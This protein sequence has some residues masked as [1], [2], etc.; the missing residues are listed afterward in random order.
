MSR[1][2]ELLAAMTPE[3]KI[4]QLVMRA[5]GFSVTGPV[6]GG[7]ATDDVR[8]GRTGSLLNVFG[9]EAT[10]AIQRVAVEESRLR[11][12]LLL[13]FDV[14]HGHRTVFPLPIAEAGAF[15]PDL[16]E[17]TARASAVEAAKDGVKLVFAPMIDIARDPRWG[18]I[19]ESPGEDPLI[20]ALFAEAKVAGL[21]GDD[22]GHETAVAATAKH[23]VAYGAAEAG[24][25]YA[26]TDLSERT[27]H[28]T[29]LPPFEAA[30]QSGVAAVMPAFSDLAGVPMTANRRLL[31]D[32]L[33]G[34]AG[35]EGVVVSDYHALAELIAHG[36]AADAVEAAAL[37][38]RAG[39]DIDM[40]SE[41]YREG[42]AP[43]LARGL[44][45]IEAV[46]AAVRR[47]LALKERLALFERPYGPDAAPEAEALEERRAARRLAREAAA[48]SI[49][50]LTNRNATLPLPQTPQRIAV[51]GPLADARADMLGC[52]SGAGE[53]RDA[54][55]VFEGLAAARPDCDWRLAPGI[56]IRDGDDSRVE[57]ALGVAAAADLVILCLGEASDMS[58][59][60]ASR[61]DLALPGL[62]Q[63]FADR[64]LALGRPVVA[65]LS[66]GRPL[67]VQGLAEGAEA[68]LATWFLGH[69][70]G[71]ALADVLTGR[72]GPS[73]RLPV[74]WPR[75]VGQ[76]PLHYDARPSGR[77]ASPEHYTSKYID[78]PVTPLFPFGHGLTYG[79]FEL[80]GLHADR[81]VA[82]SG[83]TVAVTA[84]LANTGDHF[85]EE[86][87]F[88][89]TRRPVSAVARPRLTLKA[90]G[91]LA[92]APGARGR[93]T[94]LLPVEALRSLD[95]DLRPTLEPGAVELLVGPS[96][97]PE[98]LVSFWIEVRAGR[99]A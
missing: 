55:S 2:D 13:G 95:A 19:A 15:D 96:A 17:R 25:D 77:P 16:W 39:V 53:A 84:E 64:V 12:P 63:D 76:V 30:V 70:A 65:V 9:P 61:S 10:R 58:G 67:A 57:A 47:V 6:L 36:V 49:V 94:M 26:T 88:L 20:A 69:E 35:F 50:L 87:L 52:W 80:T 29:Y 45:E 28:E 7:D 48:R 21:Q 93:L 68:L 40:M 46:D 1:I 79:R 11:I 89:F 3:E 85:G 41:V 75:S 74:T 78:G 27:L 91:R 4:G 72:T 60:A 5:A 62:Q 18:R 37:A 44:V 56:G 8:A 42:L 90:F 82:H 22:L 14:V 34:T 59:E 71:N 99:R 54:V 38:M 31:Q 83:E 23:F 81:P 73:A 43:A 92:L 86:T 51:V 66:G 33:R 32:W 24:R 98:R 97:D